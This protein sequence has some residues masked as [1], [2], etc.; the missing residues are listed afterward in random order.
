[1][2]ASH[3][4]IQEGGVIEGGGDGIGVVTVHEVTPGVRTCQVDD[5]PARSGKIARVGRTLSQWPRDR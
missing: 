1:M 3:L 5:I 4:E 2:V